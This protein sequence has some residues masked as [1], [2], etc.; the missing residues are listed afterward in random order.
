MPWTGSR[1]P[2]GGRY[3]LFQVDPV[4]PWGDNGGINEEEE[5]ISTSLEHSRRREGVVVAAVLLAFAL[6]L[7][8]SACGAGSAAGDGGTVSTAGGSATT[9]TGP[10]GSDT[11]LTEPAGPDSQTT[12]RPGGGT[13]T[14]NAYFARNEKIATASQTIAKTQGTAAAAMSLLL[15]GPNAVERGG[16]M[17]TAIPKGTRL[18]GL[19]IKNSVA[20][21]DLSKEYASG[22]EGLSMMTRLAQVVFTLTQFPGVQGVAFML[23]GK[24][25]DV[26]GG[27]GIIIDHPM[28]R[29]DYE[30]LSPAI[31]VESPAL[32]ADVDSPLRVVGTANVFEAVFRINL[33]DNDGLIIADQ[34]VQ[35]SSGTGTRGTFDVTIQYPT[36]HAGQ[37]SLIVFENSA[38][39]GSQV[40]VVEIPIA[41][42]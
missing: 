17:T 36:G 25:I 11:S 8:V 19:D 32:G 30:D 6:A 42:K 7:V 24:P 28:T 37:G 2:A 15:E 40:N 34:R 33:V 16:G 3:W 22:G 39:D 18:L 23:D 21:V 12:E 41:L 5:V 10:S 27:E 35:A 4:H 13:V 9:A 1:R 31:L 29:A 20:T 38:K 26:L 14:V